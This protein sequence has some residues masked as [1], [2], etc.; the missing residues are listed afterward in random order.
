MIEHKCS[1]FGSSFHRQQWPT[2]IL[3]FSSY[4]LDAINMSDTFASRFIRNKSF[5]HMFNTSTLQVFA[6]VTKERCFQITWSTNGAPACFRAPVAGIVR[7]GRNRAVTRTVSSNM[8][9]NLS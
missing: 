2:L 3:P 8:G 1:Q 9:I 6:L 5:N 7:P 4:P